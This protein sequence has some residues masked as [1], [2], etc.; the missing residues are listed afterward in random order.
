MYFFCRGQGSKGETPR[1]GPTSTTSFFNA[2]YWLVGMKHPLQDRQT[3]LM[4]H[5]R[6]LIV[7]APP[8]LP[9]VGAVASPQA[10]ESLGGRTRSG[11]CLLLH[12]LHYPHW[13]RVPV[14]DDCCYSNHTV[15]DCRVLPAKDRPCRAGI[16]VW[17]GVEDRCWRNHLRLAAMT[18]PWGF[19]TRLC[20]GACG[21]TSWTTMMAKN[22]TTRT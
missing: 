20:A 1:P 10:R 4:R 17:V 12:H 15:A 2:L 18:D 22:G 21:E 9:T 19:E 14:H 3:S 16:G 11:C 13:V 5:T 7:Q 8:S 6:Y